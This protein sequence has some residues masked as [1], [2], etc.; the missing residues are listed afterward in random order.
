MYI[1]SVE[2]KNF[3]NYHLLSISF[4]RETN[5]FF[6]DN[7]QGKTNILEAVYVCGTTKSHRSAY[8]SELIRFGEDEAHIRMHVNK[9]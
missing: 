4:D 8:D 6:G 2:L 9:D 3:R 5:I 7:A 1:E